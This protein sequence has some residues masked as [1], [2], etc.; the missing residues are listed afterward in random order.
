[1]MKKPFPEPNSFAS[2]FEEI[3]PEMFST[4]LPCRVTNDV[5]MLDTGRVKANGKSWLAELYDLNCS[6]TLLPGQPALAIGRRGNTLIVMPWHC[7]L[8][9]QHLEECGP[10]LKTTDIELMERHERGWRIS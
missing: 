4:G 7:L 3:E 8:W 9:L 5:R 6:A 2:P 10:W 1:M